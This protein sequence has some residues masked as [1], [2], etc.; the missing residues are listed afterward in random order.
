[1]EKLRWETIVYSDFDKDQPINKRLKVFGGWVVRNL[2]TSGEVGDSMVFVP[3]P[4]H[5][6]KL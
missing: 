5:E 4:N 2:S 1:M 6:W 3:D